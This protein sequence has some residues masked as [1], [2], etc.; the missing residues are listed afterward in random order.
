MKSIDFKSNPGPAL[1]QKTRNDGIDGKIEIPD[2]ALS[3]CLLQDKYLREVTFKAGAIQHC[4][5]EYANLRNATFDRI[6]LTGSW[7]VACN[8]QHAQFEDCVLWYVV[9]ERCE[10]NYESVLRSVPPQNNIRRRL[11]RVLRTNA[12]S[13]G[14]KEWADKIL[15][16]EL[17]AE[18]EDLRDAVRHATDYYKKRYDA[19][20]R[21]VAALKLAAHYVRFVVWGYGL[22]V[23]R[24]ILSATALLFLLSTIASRTAFT[25]NVAGESQVRGL[26]WAESLYF[27]T[28]NLTTVG[29]GDITPANAAARVLASITGLSGVVLFGF[30]AAAVYRRLAR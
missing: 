16:L 29:F 20:D 4:R 10:L 3:H 25:F 9:F 21:V 14:E 15:L 8:L 27:C 6:D 26:S 18:R 7:F 5:F 1:T 13:M 28:I 23:S 11:L 19:V 12:D 24:L 22:Y 30:I 2:V 17:K